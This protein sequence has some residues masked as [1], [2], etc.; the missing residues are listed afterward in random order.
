MP[1]DSSRASRQ[2]VELKKKYFWIPLLSVYIV[3]PNSRPL[4]IDF[5]ERS[6]YPCRLYFHYCL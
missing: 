1:E 4:H 2:K 3:G 6:L 5:T